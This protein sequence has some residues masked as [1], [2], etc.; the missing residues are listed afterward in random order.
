MQKK[1]CQIESKFFIDEETGLYN[2]IF[3]NLN[4]LASSHENIYLFDIYRVICPESICS[5]TEN[6]IDIYADD[7][8]LSYEWARYYL[9]PKIY[10]FIKDIQTIDK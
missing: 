5:F 1:N 2:H 3:E 10:K 4:R 8:H 6:G 9:A 7:D